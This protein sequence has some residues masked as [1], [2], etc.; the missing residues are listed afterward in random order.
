MIRVRPAVACL[1]LAAGCAIAPLTATVVDGD[2][3]RLTDG[4]L[5]ETVRVWGIDA[6]EMDQ[7]GG[8]EARAELARLC[9]PPAPIKLER[10]GKDARGRTVARV[11]CGGEDAGLAMI[12]A[13]LAWAYTRFSPPPDY[14]EAEQAAIAARRGI[15]HA[16]NAVPPWDW[17]GTKR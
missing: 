8:K 7:P 17:R 6:P 5:V 1:L 2:T 9:G 15:W 12:V 11:S 14:L 10:R 16:G 3:L 13:G 4:R